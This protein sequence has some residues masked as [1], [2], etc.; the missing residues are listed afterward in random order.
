MAITWNYNAAFHLLVRAGFG[1]DGK[2]NKGSDEAKAVLKLADMTQA[3]AVDY[4]L[5]VRPSTRRGPGKNE[6]DSG[7]WDKLQKWWFDRMLKAK[8]PLQEKMVLFLHQHFATAR[9]TVNKPLYMAVQNALFREFAFGNFTELVKRV[10]VDPAM[11]WW[12]NGDVNTALAPNENYSREVQELF[13]LGVFDFNGERNYSQNDIVQGARILTG[14][15]R[16]EPKETA[17]I[18]YFDMD[19]HDQAAKTMYTAVAGE[20]PN[21]D[22]GNAFTIPASSDPET[23]AGEHATLIDRV[24]LHRDTEGE[25]TAARFIARRLWKFFAYEPDVDVGAGTGRQD[26]AV[27]D[28]LAA[29][30]T[31]SGYELK[32]LLRAMMLRDEFYAD[33]T[34]TIK[35]PVEYV[36]GASRMLGAK[37]KRDA[38]DRLVPGGGSELAEMGQELLN[39]P[40]VFS[41]RGN[42]FWVTTQTFL[43]RYDFAETLAFGAKSDDLGFDLTKLLGPDAVITDPTQATRAAVVDRFLG[44][45][46]A[47][48]TVVD[49]TT[50]TQLV[51]SLGPNDPIDLTDG[52]VQSDVRGLV[53]LILVSP[54]F[55][56]H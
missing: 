43:Q 25:L 3:E 37:L 32:P 34:R 44:L 56:V 38:K 23:A 14:W 11:L 24:F 52:G 33:A 2:L 36:I 21:Q 35:G 53:N 4:M 10:N 50:T 40:D 42:L 39:P 15:K 28:A 41:W 29:D 18:S 46:L 17:V 49:T 30:F 6:N 55:H 9:S 47:D 22:P 7:M 20:T 48:P 5:D 8:K 31:A 54:H 16:D 51:A 12:L 13:T 45:L 27:I 26:L 19:D 1:H